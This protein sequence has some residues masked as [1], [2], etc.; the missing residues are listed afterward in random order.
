MAG[1][2]G[3][4]TGHHPTWNSLPGPVAPSKQRLGRSGHKPRSLRHTNELGT[5]VR[6]KRVQ[7]H[8]SAEETDLAHF[9]EPNLMPPE[10]S[11]RDT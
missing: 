4:W 11:V 10:S 9:R 1:C 2:G 3:D 6:A 5:V 7:A 8:I